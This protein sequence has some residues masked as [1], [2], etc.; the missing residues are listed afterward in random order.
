MKRFFKIILCLIVL[1]LAVSLTCIVISAENSGVVYE[2]GAEKFVFVDDDDLFDSFKDLMPGDTVTQT[3]T[4]NSKKI[5][6]GYVNIYLRAEPHGE[7]NP[8]SEEVAKTETVDS[9]HEFLS[10]LYMKV[11]CDGNLIF[12]ANPG[13]LD[14]LEKNVFI[15]TFGYGDEKILEIE[16]EVPATLDSKFQNSI[17]EVDWIFTAE[18]I[19]KQDY[20][21]TLV[22]ITGSKYLNDEIPKD[23]SFKFVL[24][25]HRGEYVQSTTSMQSNIIFSPMT[26]DEGTHVF[27]VHEV[28]EGKEGI[29]YDSTVYKVYVVVN[30]D[31]TWDSTYVSGGNYYEWFVFNN[32][33]D[34]SVEV[35]DPEEPSTDNEDDTA[36]ADDEDDVVSND[37][38]AATPVTGDDTS[39]IM[40]VVILI[41]GIAAI[42]TV[43]L[44]DKKKKK[45]EN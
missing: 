23:E 32:Y 4:V 40:W 11:K 9:M 24:L 17:G 1:C 26:L 3:V 42:V 2:G 16:L 45:T 7:S 15:G 6:T 36:F 29:I 39:I 22:H 37:K 38:E 5:G 44:L 27:T 41:L 28:N 31:G 13:E 43:F 18:E 34:E 10:Q 30:E 33:R 8:L 25:N 14:G 12:S 20:E 35:D 19:T 21:N